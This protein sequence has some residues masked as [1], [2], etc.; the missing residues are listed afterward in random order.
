MI[1]N[2][3]NMGINIFTF[4]SHVESETVAGRNAQEPGR[5]NGG[6]DAHGQRPEHHISDGGGNPCRH[7]LTEVPKGAGMLVLAHRPFDGLH[8]CA[9][10]GPIF[11]C[12]DACARFDSDDVPAILTTSPD[13]LI[14]G[15]GTDDRILYGTGAVVAAGDLTRRAKE[16]LVRPEMAYLHVRSARNNCYQCRIDRTT[17][18][19]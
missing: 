18:R 3:A 10:T 11:L 2:T 19:A 6:A 1:D 7:C 5:A 13:Y 4:C 9:E 16:L 8:P 12:T 14:K 17:P 15:Y